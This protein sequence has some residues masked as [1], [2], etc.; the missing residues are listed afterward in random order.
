MTV[1]GWESALTQLVLTPFGLVH[2]Y[3]KA[4]FLYIGFFLLLL[5]LWT[6]LLGIKHSE[7][8]S[9]AVTAIPF[10]IYQH[11]PSISLLVPNFLLGFMAE[12]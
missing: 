10:G 7:R 11:P 9:Y 4:R 1:L 8:V 3:G 2:L 6:S 12:D 5:L